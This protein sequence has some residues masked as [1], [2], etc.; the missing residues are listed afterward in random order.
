MVTVWGLEIWCVWGPAPPPASLSTLTPPS[1]GPGLNPVSS[2]QSSCQ[3]VC[4]LDQAPEVFILP[5]WHL[6]H[7]LISF[8]DG[9]DGSGS[10]TSTCNAGDL[11]LIPESARSPGEGNGYLL[12]DSCLENPMNRGTWR[13]NSPWGRKSQT[14]LSNFTFTFISYL[15]ADFQ[16]CWISGSARPTSSLRHPSRS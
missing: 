12:Q 14:R 2:L 15:N 9:Y 13:A 3:L 16:V 11:G 6:K 5:A 1:P 7:A 4:V 8:R 10:K